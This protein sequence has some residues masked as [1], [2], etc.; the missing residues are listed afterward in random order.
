M[1]LFTDADGTAQPEVWR[2]W[3]LGTVAPLAGRGC[4]FKALVT[5]GVA[6]TQALAASGLLADGIAA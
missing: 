2:R 5:G 6:V 3:H 4:A 1:S